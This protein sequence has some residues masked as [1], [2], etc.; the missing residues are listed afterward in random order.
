MGALEFIYSGWARAPLR[1][2]ER[3]A[4]KENE[5]DSALASWTLEVAEPFEQGFEVLV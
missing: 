5:A 1:W 4:K 2:L 3:S